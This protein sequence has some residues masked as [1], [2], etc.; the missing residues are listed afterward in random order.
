MLQLRLLAALRLSS[1][2]LQM[3]VCT[4]RGD[5]GAR[6]LT[7]GL[8]TSGPVGAAFCLA[9][10]FKGLVSGG[11]SRAFSALMHFFHQ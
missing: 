1:R 5:G 9:L 2:W 3:S 8:N 7:V 10:T 11:H 6:S 4:A